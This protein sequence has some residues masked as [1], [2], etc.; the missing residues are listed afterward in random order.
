MGRSNSLIMKIDIENNRTAIAMLK[1]V[2]TINPSTAVEEGEDTTQVDREHALYAAI[3][4]IFPEHHPS[5]VLPAVF[6]ACEAI[7]DTVLQHCEKNLP[8]D[9]KNLVQRYSR[10]AQDQLIAEEYTHHFLFWCFLFPLLNL[11][12]IITRRRSNMS[13]ENYGAFLI[14]FFILREAALREALMDMFCT[15][16][17]E[18]QERMDRLHQQFLLFVA[19]LEVYEDKSLAEKVLNMNTTADEEKSQTLL[20][21]S[22][23]M[24]IEDIYEKL[25]QEPQANEDLL[26]RLLPFAQVGFQ[27]SFP[28]RK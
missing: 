22:V 4:H 28:S 17:N 25:L 6:D 5:L 2:R 7:M 26:T 10:Y 13:P 20:I 9:V 11:T 21:E 1:K 27:K 16:A 8:L 23:D 15:L 18:D 19:Q 24:H 3:H 12:T 14:C